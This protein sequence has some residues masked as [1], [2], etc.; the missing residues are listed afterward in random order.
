MTALMT[1]REREVHDSMTCRSSGGNV[2]PVPQ[3]DVTKRLK[4]GTKSAAIMLQ[5]LP[6]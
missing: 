3:F 1:S 5:V 4:F 6:V 2:M